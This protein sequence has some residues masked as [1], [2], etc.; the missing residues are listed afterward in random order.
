M[1][2]VPVRLLRLE[3]AQVAVDHG[4]RVLGCLAAA[5]RLP[6]RLEVGR[7]HVHGGPPLGEH[8]VELL[9]VHGLVHDAAH[10]VLGRDRAWGHFSEDPLGSSL[11]EREG[12]DDELDHRVLRESPAGVLLDQVQ[13]ALNLG[14]VERHAGIRRGLHALRWRG[15]RLRLLA[16]HG[17]GGGCLPEDR[18]L[19]DG[20]IRLI[21]VL[22]FGGVEVHPSEVCRLAEG[23][24]ALGE[25]F[26]RPLHL[27]VLV[28]AQ[29]AH[30][31]RVEAD[32]VHLLRPHQPPHEFRLQLVGQ[33]V[34]EGGHGDLPKRA[35]RALARGIVHALGQ[36]D[37]GLRDAE[38]AHDGLAVPGSHRLELHLVGRESDLLVGRTLGQ[39]GGLPVL[40]RPLV[41]LSPRRRDGAAV[42][43]GQVALDA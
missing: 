13:Q 2:A 41:G 7:A 10:L 25:E 38:H 36:P 22:E 43:I 8:L 9:G 28:L 33:E 15:L 14:A 27:R 42:G 23:A 21:D 16:V 40:V 20:H 11:I 39:H 30:A 18:D 24:T 26:E 34:E 4:G 6:P 3:Q 19:T 35:E 5:L 12:R 29:C 17:L 31:A 1:R 37:N 32:A